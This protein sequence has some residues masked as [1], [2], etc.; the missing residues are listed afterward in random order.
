MTTLRILGLSICLLLSVPPV[1]AERGFTGLRVGPN[2]VAQDVFQNAPAW[3]AG[4]RPGDVIE[5]VDNISTRNMQPQE[6]SDRITG[7]IGTK[8]TLIIVRG[9]RRYTCV[10][11]RGTTKTATEAASAT[12]QMEA[13]RNSGVYTGLEVED[14]NRIA[15]VDLNSPAW[16]VGLRA[17]DRIETIN[18]SPT[19]DMTTEAVVHR[20]VHPVNSF[21]QLR[22]SRGSRQFDVKLSGGPRPLAATVQKKPPVASSSSTSSE[23]A[24]PIVAIEIFKQSSETDKTLKQVKEALAKVPTRVLEALKT[25]GIE[26]LIVPN[27][28]AVRPELAKEKPRGN[29]SGGYDTYA[30]LFYPQTKKVYICEKVSNSPVQ[31][32]WILTAATIKE[33]GHAFD[34]TGH[35]SA[36]DSFVKAF[37]DD[38]KHLGN[39]Q[40]RKFEYYLQEG[41]V[42]HS[43]MFAELFQAICSP[44]SERA[45]AMFN[46]FPRCTAAVRGAIGTP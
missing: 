38:G 25:A 19:R 45:V 21:M 24:P 35:F 28:L 22:I 13:N 6:L 26:V 40:R 12:L 7:P 11:V 39:E 16:N 46:A 27:I 29:Q 31:E 36:S 2:S 44:R 8:V 15:K 5:Y 43:E 18:S 37:V 20:V 14:G 17:G 3:Q 1:F 34:S 33:V 23:V 4:V 32:N 42:V 30:G 41:D 10:V 9:G